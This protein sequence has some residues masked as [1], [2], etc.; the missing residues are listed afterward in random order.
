MISVAEVVLAFA[1]VFGANGFLIDRQL[2]AAEA[3]PAAWAR[4]VAERAQVVFH[5]REDWAMAFYVPGR[6]SGS[7]AG[8]VPGSSLAAG[9][10]RPRLDTGPPRIALFAPYYLAPEGLVAASEMPVDV[11]EYYFHT[12][13]EAAL[14]LA[15]ERDASASSARWMGERSARLLTG[16][17]EAQRLSA[18]TSALAD[19]GA[20]L[21]SIRNEVERAAAR[22]AASG[23]DLC[24]LLDRPASLFGLWRQS[25]ASGSYTGGYLTSEAGAASRWARSRQALD[26]SDKDRFLAE[27]LGVAWSGDPRSDFESMCPGSRPPVQR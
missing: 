7:S 15:L 27:V 2:A 3:L 19:F 5:G 20:H 4:P 13:I 21:L 17:P 24:R 22:Q 1:W 8:L 14:D 6:V 16:V 25:I 18:Y 12:L 23:R 26:R 11:A 10:G 9:Q